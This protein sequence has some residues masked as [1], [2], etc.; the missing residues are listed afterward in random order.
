MNRPHR[1]AK[2]VASGDDYAVLVQIPAVCQRCSRP[3]P[4][5]V[6]AGNVERLTLVG[7]RTGPCPWCGAPWGEVPDGVYD[8]IDGTIELVERTDTTRD[9]L[10]R[11]AS[12]LRTTIETGSS[13]VDEVEARLREE[14]PTALWIVRLLRDP[15]TGSV[16]SAASIILSV[17]LFLLA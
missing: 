5:G 9:D 13:D 8:V 1:Q 6:V 12:I 16:L 3:F 10:L 15:A 11:A 2:P 4:S 14:A 7:N 17:V